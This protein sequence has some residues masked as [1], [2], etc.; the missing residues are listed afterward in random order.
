MSA[1]DEDDMPEA[2]R[3]SMSGEHAAS[4]GR[5]IRSSVD[6]QV[7]PTQSRQSPRSTPTVAPR[8]ARRGAPRARRMSLSLT[9]VD[10]WSMARVTFL[11]SVAGG[12]IQIVAVAVVWLVLNAMGLFSQIDQ[13]VSSTGLDTSSFNLSDVF[14]MSTIL[15]AVTIFSVMEVVLFTILAAIG[16]L[17]YNVVAAL[18]GG[19]HVV[20]GDD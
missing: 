11:L 1:Y 9:K 18:V 7:F 19:V 8:R 20:L 16:A 15:S 14:S 3:S 4:N 6:H 10:I 12:I 2:V 5:S 17:L 13:I